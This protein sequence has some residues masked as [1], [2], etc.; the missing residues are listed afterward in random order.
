M[1]KP[2]SIISLATAT[3]PYALDQKLALSTARQLLAHNFRDFERMSGVFANAGIAHRQLARPIDWYLSGPDFTERTAA[4]LEIG[5]D[6]FVSA[7][8]KALAEAGLAADTI[9][10]IVTVSSTGIATPSLEARAMGR[11]NFRNDVTRVPVFGL[12]CAGGVSGLGLAAQLA[13]ATPGSTVLFVTVELCSLAL[14]TAEV[15]KADIIA[16]ALF[17]DGAAACIL[18]AG[19][20]AREG[21]GQIVGSAEKTWPDTLD[22]MGWQIE[23]SGLGVVLNRAIPAFARRNLGEAISDMLASQ[24]LAIGD[25]D[26]F[27]CHPGGA[28]VIDAI[29]H[30]LELVSGSL[31]YERKVLRDH[32]NMSAPTVLFVLDRVRKGKGLPPRSVLFALGPGFTASALTLVRQP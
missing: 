6:L 20:D 3:A 5:L 22:I 12:G 11:I 2:V 17:G 27:I 1:T 15:G 18:R 4:Y 19:D 14:R 10:T 31:D 8:N 9:D 25:V 30:A 13:R 26:R 21:F 24:G 16:T 28:K 29:E 7:T 23:P 32:G